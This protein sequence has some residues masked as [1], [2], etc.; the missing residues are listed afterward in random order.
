MLDGGHGALINIDTNRYSVARLRQH[1][2]FDTCVVATLLHILTLQFELHS[3]KGRPLKNLTNSQTRALQSVQQSLG[4]N[5]LITVDGD[6]ADAG[7]F[8]DHYH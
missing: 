5:G 3:L 6:I 7:T 4:F 8:R 1:F 2:G